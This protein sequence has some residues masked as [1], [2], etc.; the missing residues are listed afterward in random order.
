MARLPPNVEKSAYR[1]GEYVAYDPRG[2]VWHVR[3]A[4]QDWYATPGANN[5]A[6]HSGASIT[7][8]TLTAAAHTLAARAP[9][10]ALEPF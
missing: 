4:G 5:P 3:K 9:A 10:P 8:S 1:A 2:F 6:R 7:A